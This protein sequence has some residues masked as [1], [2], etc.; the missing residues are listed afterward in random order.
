MKEWKFPPFSGHFDGKYINGRGA[1]DCKNNVVAIL[2]SITALLQQNFQP[3]RTVLLAF[4]FDEETG[5]YQYGAAKLAKRI[6]ERYGTNSMAIIID[7]GAIG[8]VERYGRIFA[9]PQSGE[10]GYFDAELTV[11]VP[12]GH[13][14]LPPKHT[15]IGILADAITVL[16][17]SAEHNFPPE[18][19]NHHPFYTFLQCVAA[20]KGTNMPKELRNAISSPHGR[21]KILKYVKDDIAAT[22]ALHTTQVVTI[23]NAGNKANALPAY[24]HALVNYRVSDKDNLAGLRDILI[25]T[26]KPVA[27]KYGLEFTTREYALNETED[28]NDRPYTFNFNWRTGLEPSPISSTNSTGWKYFSGVIKHAFDGPPSSST[29]NAN[30]SDV[31]VAPTLAGGN[32]DTRYFWGLS[33]QIYRFGPYRDIYD[34]GWGG[35]HDVNERVS[36]EPSTYVYQECL[37]EI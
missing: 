4:G 22:S 27:H 10:K 23:F 1:S 24:A 3:Q 19:P 26:L 18:L 12:G 28:T 35:I 14:S 32:T 9:I 15:S 7:E 2:S 30:S 6:E 5:T 34:Q 31:I 25:K 13:S 17:N 11:H 29:A 16:E 8:I 21:K 36:R 33:S 20:D 37:H